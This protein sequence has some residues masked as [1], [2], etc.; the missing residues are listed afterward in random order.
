[1][2]EIA[3]IPVSSIAAGN[4][5][6]KEFDQVKLEE[7]AA[8]IAAHGL[9]Q[10]IT[11]RPLSG[12]IPGFEIVAGE[13]RFRAI[14]RVLQWDTIPAIVRD[15][16]DEAAS[17]I[18]LAENTGRADLN[19]IEEAQAYQ[20]RIE[21]FDWTPEQIADIAGVSAEL[22]KRRVSLLSLVPDI[23]HMISFGHLPIGHAEAM[24]RLDRNRQLLA[25]RVLR[26]KENVPLRV[27]RQIVN[28]L[29]EEQSQD[30][31]FDLADFW[32]QQVQDEGELPRKGKRAVT[33]APTRDDL[34]E[35]PALNTMGDTTGAVLD[36]YIAQL[37]KAGF[38]AEAAAVGNLYDALVRGNYTSVPVN[39][40]LLAD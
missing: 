29:L 21:R 35:V 3:N 17:A 32:V 30:A 19:P 18:M 12:L 22:V 5:D 40:A 2:T 23:Q 8:S 14:S 1:M 4:N 25:I 31:L 7:L 34:P 15:L 13:R 37:E 24:T 28:Q 33:G 16:D 27:F 36:R 11:I 9:A 38:N 26:E 10:P 20:S 6:R 39:A